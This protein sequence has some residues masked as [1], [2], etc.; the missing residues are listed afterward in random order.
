M[1]L[2]SINETELN[3][4]PELKRLFISS[5]S[6]LHLTGSSHG[7]DWTQFW[8]TGHMFDTSV[9]ELDETEGTV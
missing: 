5:V 3:V 8:P 2:D 7:P 4:E 6:F 1:I 9:L